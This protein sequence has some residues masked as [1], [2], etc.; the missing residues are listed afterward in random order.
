MKSTPVDQYYPNKYR[1][2]GHVRSGV[3]PLYDVFDGLDY[4]IDLEP[5]GTDPAEYYKMQKRFSGEE[6]DLPAIRMKIK[7]IHS[8][9]KDLARINS[10]QAA[11][12]TRV[13]NKEVKQE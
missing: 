2:R 1:H 6:V 7:A 8:R 5:D 9:L 3:F 10:S 4:R 11:P 13:L 12:E